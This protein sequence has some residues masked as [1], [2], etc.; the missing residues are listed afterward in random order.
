[1][2]VKLLKKIRK[3]YSITH[4]PNGVF[5]WDEF[6]E[7]PITIL[8]D[9]NSNYRWEVSRFEKQ[10]AYNKLYEKLLEWI[11]QDYGTFKSKRVEIVSEELWYKK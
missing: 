10:P 3:R 4:Y 7:G 6:Y 9:R 2:K 11:Q 8:R 5:L 1:M